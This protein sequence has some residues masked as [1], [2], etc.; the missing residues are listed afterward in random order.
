MC[1]V[2]VVDCESYEY[3]QVKTAVSE[4]IASVGGLD[5][6]AEGMRVVIKANLVASANPDKAVTTH[7]TVLAALTELCIERGAS[8]VIGD[9]PGGIYTAA[10]VERIYK[11]AG[12]SLC[13]E[14][15]AELNSNYGESSAYFADIFRLILPI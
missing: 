11:S 9:S 8:V 14:K 10:F 2:S 1:E 4:A 15:G 7:P 3:G 13:V 6:L 5:G 12:L